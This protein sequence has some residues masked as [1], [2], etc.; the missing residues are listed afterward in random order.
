MTY[1]NIF[2]GWIR[3]TLNYGSP[4]LGSYGIVSNSLNLVSE[5]LGL[6]FGHVIQLVAVCYLQLLAVP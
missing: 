1:K 6:N 2:W 3:V 4:D 5:D